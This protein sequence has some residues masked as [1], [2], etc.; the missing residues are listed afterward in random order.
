MG[1]QI[2]GGG[3]IALVVAVLW[4][5]YLLPSW[6][7]K[8]R[9]NAAERNAVRLNQALRV[10]AESSETPG[11]V[12]V[13]LSR[14]EAAKHQRLV[15]RL[16]AEEDRLRAQYDEAEVERRRREH[17]A[18]LELTKRDAE[19][20]R[21]QRALAAEERRREVATMRADPRVRRA[22]ARR[23]ARLAATTLAI[24]GAVALGVGAWQLRVSANWTG[25]VFGA[26]AL[27][28]AGIVLRRMVTVAARAN[29]SASSPAE[30]RVS[31]ERVASPILDPAD[32]GWTPRQLPAPLTATAGSQAAG[33]VDAANARDRLVQ[34]ARENAA[35]ERIA[36]RRDPVPLVARDAP[37]EE[38]EQH[39]R[40][41]LARRAAS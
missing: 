26:V 28:A 17:E 41:L 12:R 27:L 22:R 7:M 39:V 10:L 30:N 4:L 15:R 2:L 24:V 32:R 8:M 1:G 18:K 14:R 35:R 13:E 29:H 19:A 37:D 11:E 31:R 3:A 5:V 33:A 34:A 9:Y 40:A 21:L 23:R 20:E 6:Q 25:V 36:R 38:I 16:E